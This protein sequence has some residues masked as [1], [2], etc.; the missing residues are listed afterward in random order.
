MSNRSGL[1]PEVPLLPILQ[2]IQPLTPFLVACR[3]IKIHTFYIVDLRLLDV[4]F[5]VNDMN[6]F[7]AVAWRPFG[8]RGEKR[9]E[10]FMRLTRVLP[11]TREF[12][13]VH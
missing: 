3:R 9:S 12:S 6:S 10:R 13:G 8:V 2:P 4:L 7:A 11:R 1:F 5:L